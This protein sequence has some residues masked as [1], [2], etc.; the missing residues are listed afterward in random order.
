M[1]TP[2]DPDRVRPGRPIRRRTS[3]RQVQ[4]GS[5]ARMNTGD[6]TGALDGESSRLL[7]YKDVAR[8]VG[9]SPW[10]VR[11][12]TDS[13]RL[14]TVRLPGRLVRIRQVDLAKFIED[15]HVR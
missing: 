9:C 4:A 13:G 11:A 14:A 6:S 7:S 10:T 8:V 2:P 5:S 12:W 15:H 1:T 3:A